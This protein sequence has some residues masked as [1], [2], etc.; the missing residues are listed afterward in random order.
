MFEKY[1][2]QIAISITLAMSIVKPVYLVFE[3]HLVQISMNAT[4]I[5]VITMLPALIMV[6]HMSV[7]VVLVIQEMAIIAQVRFHWKIACTYD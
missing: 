3:S 6:G 7:H 5:L 4:M 1:A 2:F